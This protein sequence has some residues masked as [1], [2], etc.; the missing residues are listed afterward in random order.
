MKAVLTKLPPLPVVIAQAILATAPASATVVTYTIQSSQSALNISG[1][2]SGFNFSPQSA[3]SMT[4]TF[5]GSI[6]GDL[7]GSTLTFGGGSNMN[8]DANPSAPFLPA[9]PDSG[10]PENYG[11]AIPAPVNATGAY[12]RFTLD[13][14][15]GAVIHGAPP[16]GGSTFSITEGFLDYNAPPANPPSGTVNFAG[17][18]G[19]NVSNSNVSITQSGGIETLTLPVSFTFTDS[20]D[21]VS[22][23][24]D[25]TL[26]A[27]RIIP[28]PSLPLL[29]VLAT[30][31]LSFR[32][33]R[34]PS[35]CNCR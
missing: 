11:V 10:D 26:V 32:R 17:R 6:T 15:S 30:A 3:G 25:G 34:R 35:R 31:A 7:I 20:G 8:A 18:I 4:D 16:A 21:T 23:T 29:S 28:E 1:T 9:V 14:P 5:S 19:V 33:L 27:T 22:Q 12:R 2:F 24:L 13:L